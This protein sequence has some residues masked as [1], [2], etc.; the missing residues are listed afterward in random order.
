MT[1]MPPPCRGLRAGI[2]VQATTVSHHCSPLL[3]TSPP[4]CF[5][6]RHPTPH[7]TTAPSLTP[8]AARRTILNVIR[9]CHSLASHRAFHEKPASSPCS[10][11]SA[12]FASTLTPLPPHEPP[13]P[14]S[15]SEALLSTRTPHPTIPSLVYAKQKRTGTQSS[16]DVLRRTHGGVASLSTAESTPVFVRTDKQRASSARVK[17]R[18]GVTSGP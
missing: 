11:P 10:Q 12:G 1:R 3:P 6:A 4:A 9:A 14:F 5:P 18:D 15:S 17:E 7:P 8:H 13:V 16:N 2:L